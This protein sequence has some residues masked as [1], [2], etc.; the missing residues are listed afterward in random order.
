MTKKRRISCCARAEIYPDDLG[1]IR[2]KHE[3]LPAI[4]IASAGE[5]TADLKARLQRGERIDIDV[6]MCGRLVSDESLVYDFSHD[7]EGLA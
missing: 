4:L 7:V 5:A 6:L 3:D 2:F 1:E